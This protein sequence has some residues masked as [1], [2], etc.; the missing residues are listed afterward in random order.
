MSY[1]GI[2]LEAY[3]GYIEALKTRGFKFFVSLR[4]LTI[5]I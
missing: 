3:S 4:F 5:Q 2:S 1:K